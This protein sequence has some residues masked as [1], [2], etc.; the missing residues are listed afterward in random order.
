M[1]IPELDIEIWNPNEL[2]YNWLG[3][4]INDTEYLNTEDRQFLLGEVDRVYLIKWK[5]LSYIEA[6]WESESLLGC[7]TKIAEFK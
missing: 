6:T 5:H 4:S 1:S 3:E 7:R 2:S